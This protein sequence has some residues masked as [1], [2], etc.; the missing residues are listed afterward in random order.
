MEYLL[1][2]SALVLTLSGFH[3]IPR[4]SVVDKRLST[5]DIFD[6][7][8]LRIKKNIYIHTRVTFV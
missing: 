3:C 7:T 1:V 6:D 8:V 2:Y 4:N 5:G